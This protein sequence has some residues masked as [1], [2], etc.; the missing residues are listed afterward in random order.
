MHRSA[1]GPAQQLR[2]RLPALVA[3]IAVLAI[4]GCAGDKGA[5]KTAAQ[6]DQVIKSSGGIVAS[7]VGRMVGKVKNGPIGLIEAQGYRLRAADG[8]IAVAGARVEVTDADGNVVS[9]GSATTDAEG[10][11]SIRR[12]KQSPAVLYVNATYVVGDQT[13]VL[14]SAVP[15]PRKPGEVVVTVD[16]AASLVAKKA[17]AMI[18]ARSFAAKD[19]DAAALDRVARAVAGDLDGA[20]LATAALGSDA[21]AARAFDQL[22]DRKPALDEALRKILGVGPLA[23]LLDPTPEGTAGGPGGKAPLALRPPTANLATTATGTTL[24][25][26]AGEKGF[27]DGPAAG[28]KFAVP[29][30]IATD[31]AGNA[32]VADSDNH[33]IR[34]IAPD[35]T[36]STVAGTGEPG[37][38]D[39]P[40]ATAQFNASSGVAV[41]PDG[42]LYVADYG[43]NRIRKITF[44]GQGGAT[45][46]TLA[47]N[48]APG[49]ADGQGVLARFAAPSDLTVDAQGVVFV[50]DTDNN[51]VRRIAPDGAVTTIA[52]SG[53]EGMADGEAL[54]AQLSTPSDVAVDS[55]GRV[56][57]ADTGNHAIRVL[58]DGRLVTLAGNGHDGFADGQGATA[59]FNT[60][61]GIAVGPGGAL[62]VADSSNNSVRIVTPAGGVTTFWGGTGPDSDPPKG[63]FNGPSGVAI[64]ANAAGVPEVYVADS[65]LHVLR[66]FALAAPVSPSGGGTGG[67]GGTVGPGGLTDDP[68]APK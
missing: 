31:A 48:A 37:F 5:L 34:K 60:P 17:L 4:A 9:M 22:L 51:R 13:V 63:L 23:R 54:E 33:R 10:G 7:N 1:R 67:S 58:R 20:T 56:F 18:A 41:G 2:F 16:P 64:R 52:G 62:Y 55:R 29:Y 39:G 47:G 61:Y 3:A 6:P 35:G 25:A 42:S 38:A 12:F 57:V 32:Y 66:K 68:L 40:A 36:V 65:G 24:V 21:D 28:A 11:F 50:A 44:D 59:R 14:R 19:V 45:V 30:D 46:S 43:N 15:A 49:F 26:G 53:T 27:A 8:L